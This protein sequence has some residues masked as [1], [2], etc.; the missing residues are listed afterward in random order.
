VR[1]QKKF[2]LWR[3]GQVV[4]PKENKLPK[5]T[6]EYEFLKKA[7]W[8]DRDPVYLTPSILLYLYNNPQGF[9]DETAF[10]LRL[11]KRKGSRLIYKP[12]TKVAVKSL[13]ITASERYNSL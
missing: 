8:K 10:L 11:P 4:Y 7:D 5:N 13:E 2:E 6:V 1:K 12:L 9:G 3:E